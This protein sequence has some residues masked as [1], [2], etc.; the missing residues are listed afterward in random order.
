M[1]DLLA[2]QRQSYADYLQM[3]LLPEERKD[4]GLQAAFKDIF[5][6][7]DFKETTQLDFISY[8][9]GNWECTCGRLKGVEN[10]R[11]RCTSC[12]TLLPA[13]VELTDKEICPYCGAVRK[14]EVTLCE[15]CGDT[16]GLKMKYT[17]TECLQKGYTYSVPLRLKVRLISWEKDAITKAKRLK[18]IKEQEV[19]FGDIPLMTEKGTF[20]FNGIER[21]VVSQLQRSPGVF[22]RPGESKGLFVAKIIPYRGAWVEF[23]YDSKNIL[24]VRLDR[25]KKFLATVFLRALGFSTDEDIIR[26]FH[27]VHKVFPQ[28]GKLTWELT[29]HLAG[30]TAGEDLKEAKTNTVLVPSHKKIPPEAIRALLDSGLTK[31][32]LDK[33]EFKGAYSLAGIKGKVRVNEEINDVQLEFLTSRGEPFEIFFPEADKPGLIVVNAIRKDLRKDSQQ[34]MAEIYRKLRPG[35]PHTMESAQN[36][37]QSLF[38]NPQKYNFSHIGRLK[39]NIK[40]GL[41]T[42]LENKTL[43]AQDYVEVIKYLFGLHRGEGMVDDIDHLGNRRVRSVGELVENAFRIGLTRMERTVKEKMTVTADLASAMPQDIINSKPVIAALKE[44]FGSSQL[45]QFM[46]Q[47]N[48]LAEITHKRRLSALGPGGLS[49]ERAGFE[50]RDIQ[51]SHYG[52]ICPVET[53]EGPNIG[54]I[55]SLSCFARVNPYGFIETPYRKVKDGR[56]VDYVKILHPGDSSWAMGDILEQDAY[57]K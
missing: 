13:G 26:L 27:P 39:F 36:L 3:D 7:S 15:H 46:D 32:I 42:P 34:A 56:I 44:F 28:E 24:Y 49:R 40:L 29:E 18:H 54:L 35:E 57:K 16:V 52:R 47:I 50:V 33:R 53:P 17:P 31:V 9:I 10:S 43:S 45:S 11:M 4:V 21:V 51:A 23:E 38:F 5:P 6:I 41:N 25:K 22:F 20:I 37:F 48:S 14:I 30:K 8:A 55:S 19:Y 2:I 12:Q 1:P